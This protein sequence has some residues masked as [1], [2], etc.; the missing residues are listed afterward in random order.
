MNGVRTSQNSGSS[1]SRR[2]GRSGSD[3]PD[4]GGPRRFT[5]TAVPRLLAT[6]YID[7]SGYHEV[8][9]MVKDNG[10]PAAIRAP[11]RGGVACRLIDAGQNQG[12]LEGLSDWFVGV[13][14][15]SGEMGSFPSVI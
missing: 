10:I 1:G 14:Y 11:G 8:E 7:F 6:R 3:G 5:N 2:F 4:A 9:R 15:Y 13:L 12:T